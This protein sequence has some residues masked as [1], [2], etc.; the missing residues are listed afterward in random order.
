M[1]KAKTSKLVTFQVVMPIFLSL[2]LEIWG[3]GNMYPAVIASIAVLIMFTMFT[4]KEGED[5]CS[6][7]LI[8]A[9]FT[10]C[11]VRSAFVLIWIQLYFIIEY[12][13]LTYI[14]DP[15]IPGWAVVIDAAYYAVWAVFIFD[16]LLKAFET[17]YK[18]LPRLIVPANFVSVGLT[19]TIVLLTVLFTN[20]ESRESERAQSFSAAL[21][22]QEQGGSASLMSAFNSVVFAQTNKAEALEIAVLDHGLYCFD[23]NGLLHDIAKQGLYSYA[24]NNQFQYQDSMRSFVFSTS[25]LN[26]A[27]MLVFVELSDYDFFDCSDPTIYDHIDNKGV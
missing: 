26:A 27:Q 16:T 20:S 23:V 25:H 24:E 18:Y 3:V 21:S 13:S 1:H 8:K 4:A 14:E 10:G 12:L 15:G 19:C 5:T 22:K 17:E 11:N 2:S 6:S 7:T 9:Q